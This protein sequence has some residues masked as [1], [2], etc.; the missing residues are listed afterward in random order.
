MPP[1]TLAFTTTRP[2]FRKRLKGRS[3]K[4]ARRPEPTPAP[5][6]APEPTPEPA[7]AAQSSPQLHMLLLRRATYGPTPQAIAEIEAMGAEAWLDRQLNPAGI[8]DPDGAA[9]T[10]LH[11]ELSW[12]VAAARANLMPYASTLMYAM[13]GNTIGRSIWSSRQL[14]EVMTAFWNNHLHI[15][16]PFWDAWD[17][18]HEYDLKVIRPHALGRFGDMLQAATRHTAML[19]Y[20]DQNNST[21]TRINENL[22]RELLELHTVGVENH[23]EEDVLASARMLTGL[24]IDS[25]GRYE[26]RPSAHHVGPLT[27]LGRTFPNASSHGEGELTAYLDFLA[28]HPG[29][30]ERIARKLVVRFVSDTPPASLVSRLASIYLANDTAIAPVLRALFSSAEFAASTGQKIRTPQ[31]DL[32]AL[33]RALGVT[34]SRTK[35]ELLSLNWLLST[36]GHAPMDWTTPDGFPDDPAHFATPAVAIGK[37]N[38]HTDIACNWWPRLSGYPTPVTPNGSG[39]RRLLPTPLPA[40]HGEMV[41]AMARQVLFTPLDETTL[42]AVLTYFGTEKDAPVAENSQLVTWRLGYLVAL[43]FDSSAHAIR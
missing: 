30:A 6:P 20:L 21:A 1:S 10:A 43:L 32:Y 36:S 23:R 7:P 40:T 22:G 41:Q 13:F 42:D 3:A 17:T 16:G 29:T 11:P 8:A 31:E 27:V 19:R 34:V 15:K 38:T 26:Y 24:G 5:A 2:T 18:R 4:P 12:D 35:D 39:L 28:R 14:H 37:L 25:A 33:V 9:I